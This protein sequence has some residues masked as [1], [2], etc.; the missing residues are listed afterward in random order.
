M[1]QKDFLDFEN[2]NDLID[3]SMEHNLVIKTLPQ[4]E[5]FDAHVMDDFDAICMRGDC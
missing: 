5:T 1:P 2:G 3:N 4:V